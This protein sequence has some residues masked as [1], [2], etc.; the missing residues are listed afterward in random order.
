MVEEAERRG[1]VLAEL[2]TADVPRLAQDALPFLSNPVDADRI[3]LFPECI[4]MAPLQ[5]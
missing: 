3:R 1:D 5:V 4:R 2:E